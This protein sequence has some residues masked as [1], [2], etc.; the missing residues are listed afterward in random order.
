MGDMKDYIVTK[1]AVIIQMEKHLFG[2]KY[3]I[4][5]KYIN[6]AK[7]RGIKLVLKTPDGMATYTAKEWLKGADRMEKVF[8]FP[9]Q[10]MILFGKHIKNDVFKRDQRKKE[11][12]KVDRIVEDWTPQGRLKLFQALK[13][14]LKK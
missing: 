5:D 6:I 2:T 14:V 3:Y 11:E 12:R 1:N 7:R 13:K 4:R 9:D 10:P 8:N